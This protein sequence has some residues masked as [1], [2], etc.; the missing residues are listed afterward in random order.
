MNY[1]KYGFV[2]S[3]PN[4]K[5]VILALDKEKTPSELTAELKMQDA[6]VSRALTELTDDGIVRC[7]TPDNKRGRIYVLSKDG[8]EIRKRLQVSK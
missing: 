8:V 3:A 4:R 2:V 6:N 7:L 1:E 5:R